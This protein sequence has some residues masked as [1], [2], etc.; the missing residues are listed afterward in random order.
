[1]LEQN[2]WRMN[3]VRYLDRDNAKCKNIIYKN[4]DT[5]FFLIGVSGRR[6]FDNSAKKEIFLAI[7]KGQRDKKYGIERKQNRIN[8][9]CY[10]FEICR[11]AC[12]RLWSL[13][14]RK[15]LKVNSRNSIFKFKK[16]NAIKWISKL[17]PS[18]I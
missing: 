1:M 15:M 4:W 2:S 7:R 11:V 8:E 10:F 9:R 13:S 14:L 3:T 5:K 18:R 17:N 16:N 12:R 6:K